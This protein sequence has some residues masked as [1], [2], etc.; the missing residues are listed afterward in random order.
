MYSS[1]GLASWDYEQ[2]WKTTQLFVWVPNL[3]RLPLP[4]KIPSHINGSSWRGPVFFYL[5]FK[6]FMEFIKKFPDRLFLTLYITF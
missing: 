4:Y 3:C 2:G 1:E 6:S 5:C